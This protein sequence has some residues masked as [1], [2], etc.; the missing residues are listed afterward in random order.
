M[1]DRRPKHRDHAEQLA[2]DGGNV[3][4]LREVQ[5]DQ[6]RE[7]P[8]GAPQPPSDGSDRKADEDVSSPQVG[9]RR[10]RRVLLLIGPVLM[11]AAGLYFYLS[12]GRYVSTDNAYVRA[13]KLNIATDVSGIV[14]DIAVVESQKVAK[15]Q[16]LFRLDDQPYR[17]ALAGAE[18]QLR[19]ARNEIATLQAT[20]RQGLAQIEQAKTD[21]AFY[22]TGFERQQDLS[23]R[24]VSSQAALDQAK[25]DLDASQERVNA[26]RQQAEAA[27]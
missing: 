14:S 11:V 12:G 3:A 26:A 23:R 2:A 5:P 8:S 10:L 24:G 19:T 6:G 25:R 13:D 9:P 17:I 7:A 21:V 1:A 18:A 4:K 22:Q 15:D 16:V 27:L 20:Y